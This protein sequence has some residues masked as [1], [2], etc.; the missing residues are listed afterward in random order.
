MKFIVSEGE[1][2]FLFRKGCFVKM[3]QPGHHFLF[4]ASTAMKTQVNPAAP[5]QRQ[6][7]PEQLAAFSRDADF[8]AQT[9]EVNVPDGHIALRY[10]GGHFVS[11]L[12]PGVYRFWNIPEAN[13]FEDYENTAPEVPDAIPL[14]ICDALARTGVMK[15]VNVGESAQGILLFD[16]KFQK[17]LEPGMYFFW[18]CAVNVDVKI[19]DTRLQ[20]MQLNGQ[21]ILTKD[22]VGVRLNFVCSYRITDP[23]A[24]YR[25]STDC[26]A[27]FYTAAQL[28]V[29][30]FVSGM[31]L[32]ELLNQRDTV[33]ERLLALLKPR[34]EVLHF[35]VTDAGVRDVILPGDVR[36][37][38]NTVLLAEKRAQ[39]N[40]I[41]RRE[42]VASTRSLL[43]T[44]KLLDENETLR[45]LK[46]LE[47]LERIWENVG[48][49]SVSG[50]DLLGQLRDLLGH[51]DN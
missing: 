30:D 43:N 47:Y 39:A 5:L 36:E 9:A 6:Y 14:D 2:G 32:D 38:M 15:R 28:T 1:R 24:A 46:E 27:Q 34:A 18:N 11:S 42:E 29:R 21:E 3:L 8:A 50:G 23:V 35:E 49:L 48:S 19:F 37:I 40:V 12:N 31:T 16:G 13:S 20:E 26:T 44:A 7:S 10:V 17:L 25:E 41:T 45:K 33:G 22:R 4:G 51:T